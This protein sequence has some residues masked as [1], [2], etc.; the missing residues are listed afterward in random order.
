M[1][2]SLSLILAYILLFNSI[3]I[4]SSSITYAGDEDYLHDL[5][6]NQCNRPPLDI[7]APLPKSTKDNF[8]KLAGKA[9]IHSLN[10]NAKM[11]IDPTAAFQCIKDQL[12]GFFVEGLG[13]DIDLI[14][15]IGEE[16]ARYQASRLPGGAWLMEQMGIETT[17]AK[18]IRLIQTFGP[19]AL[20]A[21]HLM[22]RMAVDPA[23]AGEMAGLLMVGLS[24]ALQDGLSWAGN[25][26]CSDMIKLFCTLSGQISYE[27][28]VTVLLGLLTAEI[29]G[30][31][32]GIKLGQVI[33][34]LAQS[35][36]KLARLLTLITRGLVNIKK[37]QTLYK[38]GMR[39]IVKNLNLDIIWKNN[40]KKELRSK[41]N[42]LNLDK[43][44]DHDLM[45]LRTFE[46]TL[47]EN[48]NL[49][50]TQKNKL[51]KSIM[52]K[53]NSCKLY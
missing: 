13:G 39:K 34:K 48:P 22:Q 43:L 25:T 42:R 51:R 27:I 28:I 8:S 49:S 37:A 11:M 24:H 1:R 35:S 47:D 2:N 19:K 44:D 16:L 4:F 36:P 38:N 53:M 33:T 40:I 12:R 18:I 6:V 5:S 21:A 32:A 26:N 30:A 29:G 15:I 41:Y 45:S 17:N 7:T 52:E 23:F 14:K 10:C 3:T 31:G 46:K 20:K 50:I 9:L